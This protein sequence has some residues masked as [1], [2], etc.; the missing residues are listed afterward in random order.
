MHYTPELIIFSF[1]LE[2][3]HKKTLFMKKLL[4]IITACTISLTGVNAATHKA[5]SS[6]NAMELLKKGDDEKALKKREK[7]LNKRARSLR[8]KEQA[9]RK[10]IQLDRKERKLNKKEKNLQKLQLDA[11]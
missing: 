9:L 11:Q 6:T 7:E 5:H 3:I 10:D 8:K 2:F 1:S 4:V